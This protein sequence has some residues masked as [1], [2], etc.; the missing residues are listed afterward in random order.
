[1]GCIERNAAGPRGVR[2]CRGE[3]LGIMEGSSPGIV[4]DWVLGVEDGI[5][6]SRLVDARDGETRGAIQGRKEGKEVAL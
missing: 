3:T 1:V 4:D 6:D 2:D 5:V